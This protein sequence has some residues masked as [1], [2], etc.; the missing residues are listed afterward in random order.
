MLRLLLLRLLR[1]LLVL[2]VLLLLRLLLLRLLLA[3]VPM[4]LLLSSM[5]VLLLEMLLSVLLVVP[6]VRRLGWVLRVLLLLLLGLVSSRSIT[7]LLP[8]LVIRGLLMLLLGLLRIDRT[9]TTIMLLQVLLQLLLCPH[10]RAAVR[11]LRLLA[12]STTIDS[13]W[14]LLALSAGCHDLHPAPLA[15]IWLLLICRIIVVLVLL[16]GGGLINVGGRL[17]LVQEICRSGRHPSHLLLRLLHHA[18]VR[19]RGPRLVR[20]RGVLR[21]GGR[22]LARRLAAV[23][24]LIVTTELGQELL[25]RKRLLV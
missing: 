20:G 19:R 25:H 9:T 14:L 13:I 5:L 2:V 24:L 7:G 16:P 4:L 3:V 10:T 1:L 11:R 12:L 18:S 6:R 21:R 17:A 15:T 8:N 22:C 23:R